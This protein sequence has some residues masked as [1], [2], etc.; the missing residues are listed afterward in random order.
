MGFNLQIISFSC[1]GYDA[2]NADGFF[3]AHG[4]GDALLFFAMDDEDAFELTAFFDFAGEIGQTRRIGM[5]AEFVHNSD[6][7]PQGIRFAED[8]H[9]RLALHDFA[10]ERF[11]RHKPH[12]EDKV[13]GVFNIVFQVMEDAPRFAHTGRRYDDAGLLFVVERFGLVHCADIRKGFES[14]GVAAVQEE[15]AGLG[16]VT[17]IMIAEYFCDVDGKGAIH[18]DG[19]W[20]NASVIEKPF[21]AINE[22]LCASHGERGDDDFSAAGDD[23]VDDGGKFFIGLFDIAMHAVSIG[24]F[25]DEGIYAFGYFWV[26]EDG[27]IFTSEIACEKYSFSRFTILE[28]EDCESG[29][30][31]VSGVQKIHS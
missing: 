2:I 10:S 21:D 11:R 23:A 24:A 9:L 6:F 15:V 26:F 14:E 1:F 20:G 8:A 31:D 19:D 17:F 29:A 30:E 18:K 3:E 27:H 12:D 25:D 28:V 4:K 16:I 5:G 22:F 7:R 13:I